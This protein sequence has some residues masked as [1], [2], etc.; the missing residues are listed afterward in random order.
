MKKFLKYAGLCSLVLGVVAF[1]LM[2]ATKAIVRPGNENYFVKG[3]MAIFGGTESLFGAIAIKYEGSVMALL[4]WIFALVALL[5]VLLGVILPLL[6]V[7]AL[8]KFAGL[9]N[10][11]ACILFALAGI[12]M[13]FVV[14]TWYAANGMDVPDK[15]AIGAGWVIG[16]ILYLSAGAVAILPAAM[17]FAAK[18]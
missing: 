8:T 1:I 2:L 12:F 13:F 11:I 3:G 4:A 15:V 7:K 6:K 17:D 9:L 16:A 14:P 10:L 5:I 18:K